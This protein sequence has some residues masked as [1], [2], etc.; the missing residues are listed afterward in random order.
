[1]K[2]LVS[3]EW[4]LIFGSTVI[5]LALSVLAMSCTCVFRAKCRVLFEPCLALA[6]RCGSHLYLLISAGSRGKP[7]PGSG[8]QLCSLFRL[9]SPDVSVPT[10]VTK[11][12]PA[13]SFCHN[14]NSQS[15]E[16]RPQPSQEKTEI[17]GKAKG[18][19]FSA[20][21]L[22]CSKAPFAGLRM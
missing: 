8:W 7:F 4:G 17:P 2:T 20:P 13:Q 18:K 6:G 14:L 22:P 10:Q 12:S 9:V 3:V 21:G 16:P 11:A 19:L 15:Q 1:M 5:T